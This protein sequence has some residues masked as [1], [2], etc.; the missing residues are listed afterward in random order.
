MYSGMKDC[1]SLGFE[2]QSLTCFL[3]QSD[4][5]PRNLFL[6]DIQDIKEVVSFER[7]TNGQIYLSQE[8]ETA[9]HGTL[10]TVFCVKDLY[11]KLL[12]TN[13][14]VV[15]TH[16]KNDQN[17]LSD[18]NRF[19]V[20]NHGGGSE[21][22]DE[23]IHECQRLVVKMFEEGNLA[24]SFTF[25]EK[26]RATSS[27]FPVMENNLA[28]TQIPTSAAS[29][30]SNTS[31]SSS[32][33]NRMH[34]KKKRKQKK[35]KKTSSSKTTNRSAHPDILPTISLGWSTQNCNEY[36]KN[37]C[38]TAGNV[39]PCLTDGKL[40]DCSKHLVLQ[41]VQKVLKDL[42]L[43]HCFNVEIEPDEVV[44]N[45]R[46]EMIGMFQEL[47]GGSSVYDGSFRIEGITVTIP[48]TIGFHRDSLNCH[49]EGMRSVLSINV[50]VP[51]TDKTV[52]KESKLRG[53]LQDNGFTEYFPLSL[54]GYS[55]KMNYHFAS[56]VSKSV[57]LSQT[58][59]LYK[60]VD[61]MLRERV[62]SVIDFHSSVWSNDN[63]AKEFQEFAKVKSS[64]RFKGRMTTTTETLDKIVSL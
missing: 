39:K 53:W 11:S 51:I 35:Y 14:P 8:L 48:S 64:S 42:P 38:T 6:L 40:S 4:K 63:F 31:S 7:N 28:S 41:C 61:W 26:K 16:V 25:K 12:P 22:G 13:I 52:P 19:S 57:A 21:Y 1:K 17:Y 43:E 62:G 59:D 47:L 44:M 23:L 9:M 29:I 2:E 56:K 58:N 54:L 33:S 32:V 49:Q 15:Y 46:K 30:I 24:N 37:K 50:K 5:V 60:I 10:P 18:D 20:I 27:S 55:R 34:N 45:V 3:Q 36:G